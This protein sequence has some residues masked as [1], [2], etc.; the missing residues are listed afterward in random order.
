MRTV[1]PVRKSSAPNLRPIA[2]AVVQRAQ[3]EGFVRPK[4]VQEELHGAGESKS[5]WKDVLALARES[6]IFRNGRYY[7]ASPISERLRQE[8]DQHALI[9]EVARR[10]IGTFRDAA[11]QQERRGEERID[12]IQPVYV[13]T[14]D[15]RVFT[16]LTRD[17]STSGMRM[18][19]TRSL[20]GQK[21]EVRLPTS[22]KGESW[23][24]VLRILWTCA[25]GDELFE[26]GGVFV[27]ARAT[28]G[29]NGNAAWPV[30]P[31]QR[32]DDEGAT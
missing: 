21:L 24:F 5:L 23:C 13:R 22:S 9:A 28:S 18:I 7:Y 3:R 20:L 30:A 32:A 6:L 17:L 4:E 11:R 1:N 31:G 27:E 19:G 15:G 29:L 14:E 8:Q 2:D 16:L 10:A 25:V 12:F 26:N